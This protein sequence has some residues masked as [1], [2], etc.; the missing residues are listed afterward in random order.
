[1]KKNFMKRFIVL[2]AAA[3]VVSGLFLFSACGKTPERPPEPTKVTIDR[4]ELTL[5]V[6][7][8][9]TLFAAST[10]S[11][12]TWSSADTAVA[13]VDAGGKVTGVGQGYTVVTASADGVSAV[14][15]VSVTDK[16]FVP[17]L[18]FLNLSAA[19]LTLIETDDFTLEPVVFYSSYKQ[20]DFTIV[21]KT[22]N[23]N[24]TVISVDEN[25]KIAALS[26]GVEILTAVAEWNGISGASMRWDITVTVLQDS[27]L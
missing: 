9:H 2:C 21:Y 26:P 24:S 16:N 13:K 10:G 4:Q 5:N 14:C 23:E 7:E 18:M 17:S 15:R 19:S 22:E 1:M 8:E 12:V 11:A 20:E 25:G 3:T 6:F 27:W